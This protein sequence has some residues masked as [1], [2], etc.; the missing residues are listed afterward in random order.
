MHS[1]RCKQLN[2]LNTPSHPSSGP[3]KSVRYRVEAWRSYRGAASNV[4]NDIAVGHLTGQFARNPTLSFTPVRSSPCARSSSSPSPPPS[5]APGHPPQWPNCRRRRPWSPSG[6]N[7][8]A[9]M[10]MLRRRLRPLRRQ[11][12]RHFRRD[13]LQDRCI[14]GYA[15]AEP[16]HVAT[17]P[18]PGR[19]PPVLGFEKHQS[20][21]PFGRQRTGYLVADLDAAV[22]AAGRDDERTSSSPRSPTRSAAMR[23][24]NGRAE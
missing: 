17:C 13:D 18:R 9:P 11:L 16:D 8:A 22:Q 2:F 20:P 4:A 6:R 7:T 24:F 5:R 3:R 1:T 23:S 15:D 14:H 12:R 19:K 10:S 21:I